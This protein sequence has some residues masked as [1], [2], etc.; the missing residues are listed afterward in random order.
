MFPKKDT[1]KP[2]S[3]KLDI[4]MIDDDYVKTNVKDVPCL[5]DD[6]SPTVK[7]KK[8][9]KFKETKTDICLIDD[10]F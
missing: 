2:L 3:I 6:D 1:N 8:E 5:I 7:V 9:I 4:C 10:D